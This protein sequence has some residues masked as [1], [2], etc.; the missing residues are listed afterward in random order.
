[1]LYYLWVDIVEQGE[2]ELV[3]LAANLG[4][5]EEKSVAGDADL[6]LLCT[7]V[8]TKKPT[9]APRALTWQSVTSTVRK[10]LV[11]RWYQRQCGAS[12]A[13]GQPARPAAPAPPAGHTAAWPTDSIILELPREILLRQALGQLF[14]FMLA[15]Q[16]IQTLISYNG[17][18]FY[19]V[20]KTN[21][22]SPK[23]FIRLWD[24]L[25][26]RL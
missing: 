15:Y 21:P 5:A 23:K 7:M 3:G 13:K 8:L 9:Q 1:M 14:P 25:E 6:W 10:T 17:H 18:E 20:K 2:V 26:S 4:A 22:N 24:N 12:G 11:S 19:K 16:D